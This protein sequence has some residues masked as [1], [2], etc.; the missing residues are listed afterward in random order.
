[1]TKA[2]WAGLRNRNSRRHAS[3]SSTST[4]CQAD[5]GCMIDHLCLTRV[6]T[7]HLFYRISTCFHQTLVGKD[8]FLKQQ[9]FCISL[10]TS[11][12]SSMPLLLLIFYTT[13]PLG[14]KGV[15]AESLETF[16]RCGPQP[17]SFVEEFLEHFPET[18]WSAREFIY[19]IV[20]VF[21]LS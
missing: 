21:Q 8:S 9:P 7:K 1:M 18:L 15:P 3:T 16:P 10:E 14:L 13:R 17:L 20:V 19:R 6:L 12:H 2:S 5:T 11:C 4:Y